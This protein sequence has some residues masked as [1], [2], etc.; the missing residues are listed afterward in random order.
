ML[1]VEGVQRLRFDSWTDLRKGLI[2]VDLLYLEYDERK[3][4]LIKSIL[5]EY[6]S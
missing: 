1:L 4:K 6:E 5:V 3:Y 2:C